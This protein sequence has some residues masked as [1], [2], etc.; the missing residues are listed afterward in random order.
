MQR[1]FALILTA[2]ILTVPV[3]A[4][5]PNKAEEVILSEFIASE[6]EGDPFVVRLCMAAAILNRLDD[7]S[8]PSTV[9][10]ILSVLGYRACRHTRD[11]DSALSAIRYARE[12]MDITGGATAWAK[13][14]T[15]DA[16]RLTVTFRVEDWVF[17]TE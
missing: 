12:G 2:A 17:G 14:G 10:G 6:T 11:Y 16:A 3:S 15:A 7:P 8:Y 13:E 9:S 5:H 1:I 4:A